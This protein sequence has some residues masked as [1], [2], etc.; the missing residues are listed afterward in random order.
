MGVEPGASRGLE[1]LRRTA[2][3]LVGDGRGILVADES[4]AA[5]T[6]RLEKAG[7]S[8]TPGNRRAFRE[9]LVTTPDLNEG[10]SGVILCDET[11]RQRA[12]DGRT[13]PRL[14]GDLGMVPG[15]AVDTGVHLLAG[16]AGEAIT[17]GMDSVGPRLAR[18]S[19][20][21]ARFAKWR[22]VFQVGA[23]RPTMLALRANAHSTARFAAASQ[24]AGVV[25]VVEPKVLVDGANSHSECAEATLKVLRHTFRALG[26]A[27]VDA[28][29]VV[30]RPTM[31]VSGVYTRRSC[32][33][34]V[35]AR[36]CIRTLVAA[37]PH[38]LAGVAFM[39][40]GLPPAVAATNLAAM[41]GVDAP[42]PRTFAFGGALVISP[43]L[44]WLGEPARVALGQAV[45]SVGVER[46]VRGLA[47]ARP[48]GRPFA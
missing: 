36:R 4:P 29:A 30:L 22:T 19:A 11:F 48:A 15:V 5:M 8:S 3:L 14:V 2:R 34:A 20:L 46:T 33:P 27:G 21:G 12:S 16:T 41:Q 17:E 26:D 42:W 10:I 9:L 28:G 31:V 6:V 43:L 40:G 7:V 25:P 32:S 44:A 39:S 13:F 1:Q 18:Y 38:D 24:A 45:L 23:G 35:V 47:P 37:V